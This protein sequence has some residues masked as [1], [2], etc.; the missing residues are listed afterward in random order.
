MILRR[1]NDNRYFIIDFNFRAEDV[2][3]LDSKEILGKEIG[4]TPFAGNSR[5]SFTA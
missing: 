3:Q 2:E 1:E 5:Y 4:E